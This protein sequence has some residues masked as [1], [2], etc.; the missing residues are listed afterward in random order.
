MPTSE[1]HQ[2]TDDLTLIR[3]NDARVKY[4]ESQ[5]HI[6]EGITYNSYVLRTSEGQCGPSCNS[7]QMPRWLE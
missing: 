3:I 7:A 4:F 6:P 1:V 5:W 2:V